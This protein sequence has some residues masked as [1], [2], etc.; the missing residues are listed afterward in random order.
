[1]F[2]CAWLTGFSW[3]ISSTTAGNKKKFITSLLSDCGFNVAT[4][5]ETTPKDWN[6]KLALHLTI[7]VLSVNIAIPTINVNSLGVPCPFKGDDINTLKA[8][9]E[10]VNK[11]LKRDEDETSEL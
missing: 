10:N 5:Q 1:M 9:L 6:M 7:K 11:N 4:Q 3:T 8:I 2:L